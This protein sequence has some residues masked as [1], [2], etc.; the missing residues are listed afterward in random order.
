MIREPSRRS[1]SST[2]DEVDQSRHRGYRKMQMERR[3]TTS[4]GE[5][6]AEEAV[7]QPRR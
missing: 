3:R 5:G 1:Q 4:E 2:R 7:S 6:M